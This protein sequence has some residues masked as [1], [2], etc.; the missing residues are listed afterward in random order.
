VLSRTTRGLALA[1]LFFVLAASRAEEKLDLTKHLH[2]YPKEMQEN[3]IRLNRFVDGLY[4]PEAEKND[5]KQKALLLMV[6]AA[7]RAAERFGGYTPPA[8]SEEIEAWVFPP[9]RGYLARCRQQ[10]EIAAKVLGPGRPACHDPVAVLLDQ[11]EQLALLEADN[12]KTLGRV[13][14]HFARDRATRE[15]VL[16]RIRPHFPRACAEAKAI[17]A[18]KDQ[19]E[20]AIGRTERTYNPMFDTRNDRREYYRQESRTKPLVNAE[21][22]PGRKKQE[23]YFRLTPSKEGQPAQFLPSA[24]TV[25]ELLERKQ[26]LAEL[27]A[28]APSKLGTVLANIAQKYGNREEILGPFRKDYP[29]ACAA[30]DGR[31]RTLDKQIGAGQARTGKNSLGKAASRVLDYWPWIVIA[32]AAVILA[33]RYGQGVTIH[34]EGVCLILCDCVERGGDRYLDHQAGDEV[35]G[36]GPGDH[37]RSRGA[38]GRQSEAHQSAIPRRTGDRPLRAGR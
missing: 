21:A 19:M 32:I 24:M 6:E 36:R 15:Q 22:I 14:A 25:T 20:E 5:L 38:H 1:A 31:L 17:L 26:Q 4:V 34:N 18:E 33:I 13:I 2:L 35:G 27:E 11:K 12:P 37:A 29:K 7:K 23:S 9:A 30:A 8:S 3:V 10:Q 28:T 16:E